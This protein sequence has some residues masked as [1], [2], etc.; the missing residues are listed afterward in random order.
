MHVASQSTTERIMIRCLFDINEYATL[1]NDDYRE[2]MD[3]DIE[4][5]AIAELIRYYLY[6]ELH[7]DSGT[8]KI[9]CIYAKYADIPFNAQLDYVKYRVYEMATELN[10]FKCRITVLN[11]TM[12]IVWEQKDDDNHHYTIRQ[13]PK[14]FRN[15]AFG[16]FA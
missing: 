8:Y 11:N 4:E 13:L 1:V 16:C 10:L 14:S 7:I 6:R 5:N 15:N 2:L 3:E 12:T 9:P